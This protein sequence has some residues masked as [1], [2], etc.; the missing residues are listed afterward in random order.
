MQGQHGWLAPARQAGWPTPDGQRLP[1]AEAH[2][3]PRR[4]A[5]GAPA[6]VSGSP[7]PQLRHWHRPPAW[8][9]HRARWQGAARLGRSG[10]LGLR[11]RND[12][13]P[14]ACRGSQCLG[15]FG[16]ESTV[17]CPFDNCGTRRCNAL[18]GIDRA[19][20][21]GW[22]RWRGLGRRCGL[23]CLVARLRRASRRAEVTQAL[24][25]SRYPPARSY[26]RA[27][28]RLSARRRQVQWQGLPG[29]SPRR[30]HRDAPRQRAPHRSSGRSSTQA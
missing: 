16:R 23:R 17:R 29:A 18:H 30:R 19:A 9:R 2:R 5:V 26:R 8:L 11:D 22:R 27:M 15:R 3:P 28:K 1:M 6:I 13:R 24:R 10:M 21:F 4:W 14:V 25:P 20:A 7:A 12:G